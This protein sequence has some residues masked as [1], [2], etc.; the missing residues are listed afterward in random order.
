MKEFQLTVSPFTMRV[1]KSACGCMITAVSYQGNDWSNNFEGL[2]LHIRI[3]FNNQIAALENAK[4]VA[5]TYKNWNLVGELNTK[6]DQLKQQKDTLTRCVEDLQRA[7]R[8][9][10]EF[11]VRPVEEVKEFH[12]RFN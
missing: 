5:K 6:I 8:Q 4:E 3:G 11:H 10:L 2:K 12:V 1:Y 9:Y 7:A